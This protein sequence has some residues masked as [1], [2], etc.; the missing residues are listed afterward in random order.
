MKQMLKKAIS[1]FFTVL[2][3]GLVSAPTIIVAIDDS[4]DI[5]VLYSLSEEEEENKNLELLVS[6]SDEDSDSLLFSFRLKNSGYYVDK[7]PKPHTSLIVPPPE[8]FVL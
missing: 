7:Y 5:S 3:M 2:F 8:H 1:I 4:I 6:E